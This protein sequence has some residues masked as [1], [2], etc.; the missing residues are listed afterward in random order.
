LVRTAA[1]LFWSQGYGQTGVNAIIRRAGATSGSFYHFFPTKED[2]LI[3]VLSS[4]GETL[5]A[6]VLAPAESA[7][8]DPVGR[9][10]MLVSFYR[11]HIEGNDFRFGSPLGTL[12][13]ELGDDHP[14]ARRKVAE[15]FERLVARIEGWFVEGHELIP[16][17][18][19]PRVVAEFVLAC[20]EGAATL[21]RARRSLAPM[22]ACAEQ[23]R[24]H[25]A[26]SGPEDSPPPPRRS[27]GVAVQAT[28]WKSW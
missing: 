17:R 23:L 16:A 6:E 4:A 10:L 12:V 3:S 21:A 8:G 9:V 14:E 1:E 19:R 24:V 20:L 28:D 27:G 13:G 11:R 2:L 22:D 5:D 15:I 25:L 18:T 7:S 26:P